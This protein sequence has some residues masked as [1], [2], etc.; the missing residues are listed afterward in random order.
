MPCEV[1]EF[2]N[3]EFFEHLSE[4]DRIILAGVVDAHH[5]TPGMVLFQAGDPGE[6]LFVVRK[7]EIELFIKDTAGQKIVLGI[8]GPGDIFGELALLDSG[9]RTATAVALEDSELLEL[10]RDDL[11]VLF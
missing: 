11:L 8:V 5:M 10:D 1:R 2:D 3:I 9:S 6:S 7:G 4:E